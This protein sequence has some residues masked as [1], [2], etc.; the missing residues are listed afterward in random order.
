MDEKA[1]KLLDTI[2]QAI[3]DKK[4]I[5]I[6]V[7]DVRSISTMTHYFVIAEGT[8]DRHVVALCDSITAA[9]S[10]K[11]VSP[12]CIEGKDGGDWVVVDYDSVVVHLFLPDLRQKYNLEELWRQAE[13]V[14]V[15]IQL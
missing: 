4:G 10:D 9:L 11:E 3:F 13:V 15:K 14:D 2:A 6:L 12:F 8:S 1:E 5:N 7:L